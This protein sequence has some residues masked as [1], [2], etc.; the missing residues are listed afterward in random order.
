MAAKELEQFL[1][2]TKEIKRAKTGHRIFT[3]GDVG[4]S[5]Y[6]LQQGQVRLYKSKGKGHFEIGMVR[7]GEIFGEHI[8]WEE[9]ES[10]P[11]SAE[12]IGEVEYMEVDATA[13]KQYLNDGP[14]FMKALYHGVNLQLNKSLQRLKEFEGAN[15]SYGDEEYIFIKD[16]EFCKI[17]TTYFLVGHTFGSWDDSKTTV[18]FNKKLLKIYGSDIYG[19]SEAKLESVVSLLKSFTL[20]DVEVTCEQQTLFKLTSLDLFRSLV[21]TYVPLKIFSS[22]S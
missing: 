14:H 10:H 11:L 3:E 20:L 19:M 2:Q 5:V 15:L 9:S 7:G 12:A 18:K 22:S 16:N 13:I 4:K 6:V 8:L 21:S 1:K 17:L